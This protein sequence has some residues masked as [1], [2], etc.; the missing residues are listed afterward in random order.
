MPDDLLTIFS[1]VQS[2]YLAEQHKMRSI[3]EAEAALRS[4]LSQLDTVSVH[5]AR[6]LSTAQTMHQI[7]ADVLWRAWQDKTRRQLN[8]DLARILA[9]K[10]PK[11]AALKKAFGRKMAVQEMLDQQEKDRKKAKVRRIEDRLNSQL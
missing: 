9:Q 5:A 1:I 3:L 10:L 11:Q 2:Q 4:R 8:Q 6:D 7:G